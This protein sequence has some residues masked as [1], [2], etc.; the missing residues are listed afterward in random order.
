MCQQHADNQQA[1]LPY[2]ASSVPMDMLPGMPARL[3]GL[4]LGRLIGR[5][6]FGRVYRGMLCSMSGIPQ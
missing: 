2:H 3:P 4:R 1:Q 5:G 6:S